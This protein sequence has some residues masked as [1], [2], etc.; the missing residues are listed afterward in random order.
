MEH[1]LAGGESP[2]AADRPVGGASLAQPEPG[3]Q[4]PGKNSASLAL[5]LLCPVPAELSR[6]PGG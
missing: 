2:P 4:G 3:Q 6:R 5:H 1:K